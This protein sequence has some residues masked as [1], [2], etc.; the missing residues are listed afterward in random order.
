MPFEYPCFI[1]YRHAKYEQNV[2]RLKNIVE[3]LASKLEERVESEVYRD[4]ERLKG[5]AFY[6]EAL[7]A[8]L[9]KS[10][11]MIALYSPTYFSSRHTFC[12][13]EFKAMQDLEQKR[14]G[15]LRRAKSLLE[16]R[17]ALSESEAELL[18]QMDGNNG[19][20]I[21]IALC[22]FASIPKGIRETRRCYDFGDFTM[23]EDITQNPA[24]DAKV[25]D[26]SDYIARQWR[27][28]EAIEEWPDVCGMCDSFKLPP[29]KDV[30]LW[31]SDFTP[32]VRIPFPI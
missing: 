15:A 7:A 5:A 8:A 19:L 6:N 10:V 28:F 27:V 3:S 20:I 21:V 17:G 2:S 1:S 16:A 18:Q 4:E 11:C 14:L 13:R 25:R 31:L 23:R 9:C 32:R 22:G 12:S 29:E 24:F 26:I 30:K